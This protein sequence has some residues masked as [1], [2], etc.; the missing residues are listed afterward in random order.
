MGAV[1][2]NAINFCDT[3]HTHLLPA[4]RAVRAGA[5]ATIVMHHRALADAAVRALLD[6]LAAQR[7]ALVG[8]GC[9]TCIGNSGP[10]PEPVATSVPAAGAPGAP[11]EIPEA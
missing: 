3:F 11:Q 4:G 7:F 5:A 1:T 2:G 10:L 8:Y 6:E 9:T